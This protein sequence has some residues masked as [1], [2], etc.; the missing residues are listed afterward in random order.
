MVLVHV[1][2]KIII[3]QFLNAY[4]NYVRNCTDTPLKL[5]IGRN[6]IELLEAKLLLYESIAFT[7]LDFFFNSQSS[8]V[9]SAL[10]RVYSLIVC[11]FGQYKVYRLVVTTS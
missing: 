1:L 2:H 3:V 11:L 10:D 4:I 7:K 8:I 5:N 6:L 9:L